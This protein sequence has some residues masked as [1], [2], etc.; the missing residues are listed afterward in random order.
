VIG[1]SLIVWVAWMAIA[2]ALIVAMLF[3]HE[4]AAQAVQA[5]CYAFGFPVGM[6]LAGLMALMPGAIAY[7]FSRTVV[8]T[9]PRWL[10]AVT[11][12]GWVLLLAVVSAFLYS[13]AL[14]RATHA[15]FQTQ[16]PERVRKFSPPERV[17]ALGAIA[18]YI[19]FVFI[20]MGCV[21]AIAFLLHG[22]TPPLFIPAAR[23][24]DHGALADFLLW[25]LLD[26][27]PGLKVPD[28]LR[29]AAPLT[30][31][32]AG[33]GWLVLLFKVMVIVPVVSGIGLYLKDDEG[34][35]PAEQTEAM[36]PRP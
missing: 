21:A 34:A 18:L 7:T 19:N 4:P 33:A 22:L 8:E 29:W 6:L 26:A 35:P 20:A 11:L 31:E 25:Q 15:W 17:P 36:A 27:I 28:T 23:Q 5:V 10:Q 1:D 2:G 30:Y 14:R 32:R 24:V 16:A 3:L 9:F 13:R 12:L